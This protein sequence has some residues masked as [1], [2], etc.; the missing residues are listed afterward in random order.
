MANH[1]DTN[2]RWYYIKDVPYFLVTL[3]GVIIVGIYTFYARQQVEGTQGANQI[4]L[5]GI[6]EVNRP[7]IG[8]SGLIASKTADNNGVHKRIGITWTNFGNTPAV[9]IKNMLCKP[10]VRDDIIPPPYKCDLYE[11]ISSGPNIQPK[12]PINWIGPIISDSDLKGT[13]TETKIV[14]VLGYIAYQDN[15]EVDTEG[16]P[17]QRVSSACQRIVQ[18]P[19]PS[20]PPQPIISEQAISAF[21]CTNFDYCADEGCKAILPN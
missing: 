9:S 19:M 7:Y 13:E 1:S 15:T 20:N 18:Q 12:Q 21:S 3:A 10:I 17:L 2:Q 6:T 4:S 16:K 14:Y 5:H 11:P 8:F